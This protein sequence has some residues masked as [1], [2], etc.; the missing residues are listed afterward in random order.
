MFS[1]LSYGE[2]GNIASQ[3]DSKATNM[4]TILNAVT[5]ELNKIG[6]EGTWSGTAASTAK[7]EFDTLKAKFPEFKQAINDCAKYLRMTVERYQSVDR[8]VSG[9]R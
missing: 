9:Q 4:E 5:N 6:N 1:G 2:I 3:L 7:E 8:A